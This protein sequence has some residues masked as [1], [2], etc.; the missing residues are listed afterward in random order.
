MNKNHGIVRCFSM[1][2]KER[3]IKKGLTIEEAKTYIRNPE[4]TSSFCKN[5]AGILRTKNL[6]SW[7]DIIVLIKE[8]V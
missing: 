5:K 2:G 3:T 7:Y 1:T 8:E 4:S 6:G